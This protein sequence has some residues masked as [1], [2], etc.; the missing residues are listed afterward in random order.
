M[1]THAL[2]AGSH[3]PEAKKPLREWDMAAL[4]NRISADRELLAAGRQW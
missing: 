2:L 4:H 1:G 3:H